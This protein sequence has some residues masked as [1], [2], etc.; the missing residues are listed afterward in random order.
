MKILFIGNSY[1]LWNNLPKT[2]EDLADASGK[3]EKSR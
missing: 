3:E 1:L 2:L